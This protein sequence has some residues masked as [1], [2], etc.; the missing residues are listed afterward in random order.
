MPGTTACGRS[1]PIWARP[2]SG[3]GWASATPATRTRLHAYV[4]HD[5]AKAEQ[6]W[7][8]DLL[9]GISDGA[10][11]LAD[12]RRRKIHERG[13]LAHRPAAL[14]VV[15]KTGSRRTCPRK[16]RSRG[17]TGTKPGHA[18]ATSR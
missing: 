1:M 5:F 3:S 2:M 9:R 8:E 7:L 18:P 11:F 12:G 13:R 17:R 15:G 14:L 4:L 16:S 6:D 10:A